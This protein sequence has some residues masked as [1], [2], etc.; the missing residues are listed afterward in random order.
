MM[1][2]VMEMCLTWRCMTF[3]GWV[4][5]VTLQARAYWLVVDDIADGV[6]SAGIDVTGIFAFLLNASFLR[7]TAVTI[8]D[9]FRPAGTKFRG[10]VL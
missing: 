7:A 1:V 3:Q 9:A 8:R 5:S 10:M 6:D 4:A 2:I